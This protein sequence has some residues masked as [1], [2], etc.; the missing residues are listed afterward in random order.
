[1]GRRLQG[2]IEPKRLMVV[3]VFVAGGD[4]INALSDQRFAL[5]DRA[6]RL[7]RP[8]VAASV[9][10]AYRSLLARTILHHW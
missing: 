6:D 9:D 4:T 8:Q 5:V 2:L 3:E 7:A 1:M 10:G